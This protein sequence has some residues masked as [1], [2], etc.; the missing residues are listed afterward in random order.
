MVCTRMLHF[1]FQTTILLRFFFFSSSLK[2][3]TIRV[4][5]H[6]KNGKK[7]NVIYIAF[8]VQDAF[9]GGIVATHIKTL[10]C[11]SAMI[12]TRIKECLR[13][14]LKATCVGM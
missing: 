7:V 11:K 8:I 9:Y 13:R 2:K 10:L 14:K 3:L 4:L 5:G 6:S 1:R 12:V